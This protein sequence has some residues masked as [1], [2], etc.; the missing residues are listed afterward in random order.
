MATLTLAPAPV[1]PR[2]SSAPRYAG[3]GVHAGGDVG[4]GDADARRLVGRAGNADQPGFRL[5]QQ[6]V[7]LSFAPSARS[8]RSRRCRKPRVSDAPAFPAPR[9]SKPRR[10]AAPGARFWISTSAPATSFVNTSRPPSVFTSSDTLRLAAVEPDEMTAHAV[11]VMIV[12]PGEV[13]AAGTLDLDHV[14]AHVGQVAAAQRRRDGVFQRDDAHSFEWSHPGG[15]LC[16]W[17]GAAKRASPGKSKPVPAAQASPCARRGFGTVPMTSNAA[18]RSRSTRSSPS[19]PP[20]MAS[21]S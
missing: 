2:R 6:V 3:Q 8:R 10:A 19:Q 14:G 11:D 21:L 7:G 5:D 17:S 20:R 4:D 9:G 18:K 1:R 15:F 16:P 13:A 12:F